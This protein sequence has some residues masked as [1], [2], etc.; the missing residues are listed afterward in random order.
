VAK[1]SVDLL[2][3][4]LDV[5]ILKTLSWGPLHGYGITRRIQRITDDVLKI[6]EG[7][8]YPAL[9][10]ME[11]RGLVKAGW[12]VTENKRRAKYYRLTAAGRR[13]LA[14]DSATWSLFS[15]AVA[16]VLGAT[17]QPG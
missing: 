10:R 13:R 2:Q 17:E 6:E 4:T 16:R 5:L 1:P 9:Y 12:A 14:E 15:E 11:N 8:M 3:G 7:S